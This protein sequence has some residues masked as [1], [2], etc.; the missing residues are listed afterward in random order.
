MQTRSNQ[1]AAGQSLNQEMGMLRAIEKMD[2]WMATN[3][4]TLADHHQKDAARLWH[5]WNGEKNKKKKAQLRADFDSFCAF[6]EA[7]AVYKVDESKLANIPYE[8]EPEPSDTEE[9]DEG[10]ETDED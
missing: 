2:E 3:H 9:E 1:L 10:D 8:S 6:L 5:L 7:E 4:T